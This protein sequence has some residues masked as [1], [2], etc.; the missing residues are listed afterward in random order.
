MNQNVRTTDAV[1]FDT[2]NTGQGAN[3]LYAMNQNVRTTD[4]VIFN[5]VTSTTGV[6]A[7]GA[8]GFYSSTYQ[9][10]RNP[11]WRFANADAYGLS[12][13]QG[14]GGY[15][16]GVDMIGMH[17]GTAT[18]GG[19]QFTFVQDGRF[20][21]TGAIYFTNYLYGNSKQALDTTDSY[22]RLNQANQFSSGVYTPYNFRADGTIYVGGTTYYINNGTSNLNALTLASTLVATGNI[23]GAYILGSYFNASAGN[24]E[25]P[26]IGQ[27]WTQNTTDNYLRKSTPAHFRSQVMAGY[28]IPINP[29]GDGDVWAYADNNPTINGVYI[30]GGH[31]FGA[32]G[33]INGG[34]LQAKI[35]NAWNGFVNSSNGYYLGTYDFGANSNTFSTTRVIDSSG[36]FYATGGNITISKSGTD[37]YINFSAQSNDPGYIRHYESNN[38]ARMYFS[39][40]DDNGKTDYFGFGYSGD[41]E[42]AIIYADGTMDSVQFRDRDNTGY[43]LDP[44]STSNLNV[45][46]TS[47]VS[48]GYH[49]LTS[50]YFGGGGTPS[51]GYLIT[52]NIDYSSFNMPT[53][54]IEGY[55]YGNGVP[56][57]LEIVWYSYSNTFVN[58]SYNNLGA[59]DPGTVRIGTNGSGKVCIHLSNNIYYG[60]FN[61]RCIYDQGSAYLEGWSISET[62]Y[63]VLSRLL[64]VGKNSINTDISGYAG[65]ETLQTVTNRG[66]STSQTIYAA[67]YRGNANVGGT[68]EAIY[69]PAGVYSTGTNWL[70]GTMYLNVNSINDTADIRTYNSSYS[71][72]ARYTAGSDIYHASL[73]WYGLQLGNNGDNYIIAGRT[74]TGGRLRFYVNNTSDFTSINGTEGMRLDSDGRLYSYV[75]TRSPRFYDYTD[76]GYYADPASTNNFNQTEQNGRLWYSNYLVSRNNGGLMGDYNTNGTSSKVIWTIGESWPI[77]NMY[78]L[79]Y[80]YGS[81]YDHH[82]ALR[83]NGSTYSRIGFA[84]GAYI[85]GTT[86]S[87]SSMR[88]PIFYE[89]TDT[90]YYFDGAA[91]AT[92]VSVR[93]AGEIW[94]G[95]SNSR[96]GAVGLV[97]NDGSMLVRSS[98]DNYHKIWYY[99]GIAFGTNS[100]HGHFRFY[101]ETNT[102]RNNGTG[103]ANLWFDI[104]ATN[105]VA[106][107]Y[108]D[109]RAPYFYDQDNTGYFTNPL[110]RSRL[111]SID[112]GD[113]GYYFGGG[114]WGWRHN[115]PYGYI[116]FGPAN[117]GH[118]HIYTDRSNFYFNVYDLY[119]N[120]YR[121]PL[122]DRWNSNLYL[123]SGGD[124][125]GTIFYDTNDSYYRIDP[126]G[127]TRL[128]QTETRNIYINSGYM[129]Y[130]DMGGWQGEYNK[131]QWH[132]SH[133]YFQH[134]SSGYFIF[135]TDS[136]AERAYINRSG[137]LYLGY[138]GWLSNNVNQSVR[139][140]AGPTFS[141][142]YVNGWYR[143]NSSNG[144]YWQPYDRG[145]FSPE[146][147]GNSY[148]HIT[149]YS[150]GRNGWY[151]YGIGSRWTMMSS[152]TASDNFGIHDGN[153]TWMYLWD[154]GSHRFQYGYTWADGSMRTPI[155]Y[156]NNDTGYYGDFNSSTN[157]QYFT[158]R[159]LSRIHGQSKFNTP[160]SD[161]TGDQNYWTGLMGWGNSDMNGIWSNWGAG[162]FD[163]WS[164]PGNRP[165]DASS[166]WNGL[167]GMHYNYSNSYNVYGWQMAMAGENGNNRFYWR[168]SWNAPRGWSEML[169]GG[170]Y[171]E[172]YSYGNGLYALWLE[173]YGV[174]G[175]SGNGGHAYRIFQEGGG[176]GYPYPDLRIAYHVGM[177]FGSNPSYEGMR[178]Y[179][180]YDMSSIVWQFNGGSNYSYQYRWNQ[181]TDYHGIYT[182]INSA[183]FYPNN[184]S[185]GSWRIAGTRNGWGGIEFDANGA[186][187]INL[188]MKIKKHLA[189]LK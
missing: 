104:N 19:S 92:G 129:L 165:N 168:T 189:S 136:G 153:R 125:Y 85:S 4:D 67:A 114:S 172:Y 124:I 59:W 61:V 12:Y 173:P 147:G 157:L 127:T 134:Q 81:G 145:F 64:T 25:N 91:N 128:Q 86:I 11:I 3:E 17:F 130:S 126:N 109:M 62:S 38:T 42:R 169:H 18:V 32:D 20:L 112:Y 90:T 44:A 26:T 41:T 119:A 131:I 21:T 79:G 142:V 144:F 30:G 72:R 187:Q 13:F 74:N 52:T 87:D 184:A 96:S 146:G 63:T 113:G 103:G 66:N 1:T 5:K 179:T 97:L 50:A 27:I 138:L 10:G 120:G 65:A 60:R 45:V 163:T 106:I 48:T 164:Y 49:S 159:A 180:D 47:Q 182:G 162:H 121:G 177:K 36:N 166:H 6:Y 31:S 83:N 174:G 53:V 100:A 54:I 88:S 116:E 108:G 107:S 55:A 188:M 170:N 171:S 155:F 151:G 35:L 77:G 133:M 185:Y 141:Q 160:R 95:Q 22:L 178:F 167:Q 43:Y 75:D 99:D 39:V 105:G 132:S 156:D 135:R 149:T 29:D 152:G 73:N 76:T 37:S 16:S 46:R 82:L 94:T 140:D 89:Y 7:A 154:G 57:H 14:A 137:D 183:H 33:V 186:G 8:N 123:G 23:T 118:A 176:W 51:T 158:A 101:G 98:G 111:Q 56:I 24:S 110:G 148:G 115:T 9:S 78:G 93:V 181:L 70:Y 117:S 68:G 150:G 143:Q 40:S 139:S 15:T 58:Y 71:F 34:F 175:N 69:A 122:I 80:E 161:Y 28:Y 84:G 2:V 102:Q